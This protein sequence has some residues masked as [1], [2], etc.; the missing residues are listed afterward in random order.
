MKN[1]FLRE[2]HVFNEIIDILWNLM[3]FMEFNE[4][5]DFGPKN[6]AKPL[7]F[8]L[9]TARGGNDEFFIIFSKN[10]KNNWKLE[11]FKIW[12]MRITENLIF[13]KF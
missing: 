9:F 5:H 11:I 2:F 13:T 10:M 8:T 6:S 3:K 1:R 7:R 4:F 12:N